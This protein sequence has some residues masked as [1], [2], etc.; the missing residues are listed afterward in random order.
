MSVSCYQKYQSITQ[1]IFDQLN[2]SRLELGLFA[3][4]TLPASCLQSL[5]KI[6]KDKR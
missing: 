3:P 2:R 1:K 5:N 6:K 4:P